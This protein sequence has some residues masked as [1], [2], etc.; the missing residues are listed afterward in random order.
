MIP[1]FIGALAFVTAFLR[2]RYSL[3][4]EIVALRQQLGVLKRKHTRP[5]LRIR[6]RIF[7]I[8]LRRYWPGWSS[9]L[10]IVRLETVVAWH[11][12]GFRL[13]WR[14]KSRPKKFGRPRIDAEI[15]ALIRRMVEEN[16]GWGA[17]RVHGE[18]LKLGFDVSECTVSRY[19]RRLYPREQARKL[20]AAFLRNHRDV[21]VAMDFFTVPTLTFRVLYCFFVIEHGR[22]RIVHFNVTEHPTGPWIVQQLREAFPD[23][24]AYR[25]MILDR[26]GKFGE[27][28]TDLL[29][30]SGMKPRRI[31]P[32]CPWQNGVSERWIGSCRRELLDHLIVLDDIHLRRVIRDYVSYYRADRIH[33]SLEKD[34]PAKRPV[35]VK[36]DQSV[37]LI[38]FPRLGGLHHRYDWRQA[39]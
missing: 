8:L 4:L 37:Q 6:D 25:Y 14:L 16:A 9:A 21:I 15:R 17:P 33:D 24:C 30:A 13:F 32:A 1:F 28:V 23:S 20:W 29:T 36:P 11:R 12:A 10:V 3:G 2:S 22:R 35:S 39:A 34:T 38:S 7:W 27:E 26:D 19:L 5:R 18:L 31:S